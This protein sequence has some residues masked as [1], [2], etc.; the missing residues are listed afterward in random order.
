MWLILLIKALL[1]FR[2]H[3]LQNVVPE[4]RITLLFACSCMFILCFG[5]WIYFNW[6]ITFNIFVNWLK[7]FCSIVICWLLG[8]YI[9]EVMELFWLYSIIFSLLLVGIWSEYKC[10]NVILR[11]E[12][13][14]VKREKIFF[15]AMSVLVCIYFCLL[16]SLSDV[17][18]TK[19]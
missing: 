8:L 6:D 3:W 9:R 11:K 14:R 15:H 7:W 13:K 19:K 4:I 10:F 16:F 2:S 17:Q 1:Y 18:L 12:K 5:I